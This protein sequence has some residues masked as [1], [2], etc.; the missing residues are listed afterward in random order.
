MFKSLMTFFNFS[1]ADRKITVTSSITYFGF[2][3]K[4]NLNQ[5]YSSYRTSLNDNTTL[6]KEM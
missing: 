3:K 1:N 6:G 4:P 5:A 2:T